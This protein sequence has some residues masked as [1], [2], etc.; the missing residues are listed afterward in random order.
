[1]STIFDEFPDLVSDEF[2]SNYN[3]D[4]C[5][6]FI[7][8]SE[9]PLVLDVAVAQRVVLDAGKGASQVMGD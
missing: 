4:S 6:T 7:S 8:P 2:V 3:L 5:H 1:M 9:P